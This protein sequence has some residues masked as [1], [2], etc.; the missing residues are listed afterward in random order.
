MKVDLEGHGPPRGHR[1]LQSTSCAAVQIR[2]T[3]SRVAACT[4]HLYSWWCSICNTAVKLWIPFSH[5]VD[6]E[7]LKQPLGRNW[8]STITSPDDRMSLL[9]TISAGF[10]LLIARFLENRFQKPAIVFNSFSLRF[11]WNYIH[12]ILDIN[13]A[14]LQDVHADNQKEKRSTRLSRYD[15]RVRQWT[16]KGPVWKRTIKN[17]NEL[18]SCHLS[19]REQWLRLTALVSFNYSSLSC[20]FV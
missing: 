6:T 20:V 7:H 18:L 10:L 2:R 8:G 1:C 3:C 19:H 9:D 13:V 15:Y 16:S 11:E 12:N 14:S 4:T 17:G 5:Y